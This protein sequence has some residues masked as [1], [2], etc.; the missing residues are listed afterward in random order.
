[1]TYID[2]NDGVFSILRKCNKTLVDQ[3][4]VSSQDDQGGRVS[5]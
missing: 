1:M 4:G 3:S 2:I 5:F